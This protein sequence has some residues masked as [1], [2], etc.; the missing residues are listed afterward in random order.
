MEI[1]SLFSEG[2]HACGTA[3]ATL[4]GSAGTKK[5]H[6]AGFNFSGVLRSLRVSNEYLTCLCRQ[7]G[8][9]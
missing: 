6:E 9:Q 7:V 5:Y 8:S 2:L 1:H 4:G 3:F